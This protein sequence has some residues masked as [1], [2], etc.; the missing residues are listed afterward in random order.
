MTLIDDPESLRARAADMRD[1]AEKAQFPETKKGLLRIADDYDVLAKR[2][3]QRI[4][5]L[6]KSQDQRGDQRADGAAADEPA[7]MLSPSDGM[8]PAVG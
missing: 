3:E 7:R 6:H 8:S 2:A 5:W 1:R 4:A